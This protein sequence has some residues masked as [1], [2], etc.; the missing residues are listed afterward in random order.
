[1]EASALNQSVTAIEGPDEKGGSALDDLSPPGEGEQNWSWKLMVALAIVI[2]ALLTVGASIVLL[3]TDEVQEEPG[4]PSK[5]GG[6][7]DVTNSTESSV[8]TTIRSTTKTKPPK[9]KITR[10][11]P[12]STTVLPNQ[13]TR[14][15][16]DAPAMPGGRLLCTVNNKTEKL[17][18]LPDDGV[19]DFLFYDSLSKDDT[20]GLQQILTEKLQP[21]ID[22][23]KDAQVTEV[24]LSLSGEDETLHTS[25]TSQF[26]QDNFRAL[27]REKV[28]HF[29]MLNLH[30]SYAN[31]DNIKRCLASLMVIYKA[32]RKYF[33]NRRT[34]YTVLG[35]APEFPLHSHITDALRQTPPS[36]VIFLTHVSFE[37]RHHDNCRMLPASVLKF[38]DNLPRSSLGYGVSILQVT[39]YLSGIQDQ[40]MT[41]AISFTMRGHFYKPKA[42]PKPSASLFAPFSP[43]ED[44]FGIA[45][46]EPHLLC[47]D[48][49]SSFG[50][51]MDK[52]NVFAFNQ[53]TKKMMMFENDY[54]LTGK[55]CAAVTA[56][57]QVRFEIAA[58]DVIYDQGL[59]T[60]PKFQLT[61]SPFGRVQT[62]G[63]VRDMADKFYASRDME[64]CLKLFG[65]KAEWKAVSARSGT[66]GQTGDGGGTSNRHRP[67]RA[68]R[69]ANLQ[70]S[71]SRMLPD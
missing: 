67:K 50:Y 56:N 63:L 66:D 34:I 32:T 11:T 58:Y 49:N 68:L 24:G 29:G 30:G 16:D 47:L 57:P 35:M 61:S 22:Y 44:F 71:S 25:L 38:P 69:R 12:A 43:C 21:I 59:Y 33:R 8:Q 36:L 13:S 46:A 52:R 7:G 2:V 51:E 15:P 4:S 62:L 14:S 65:E 55:L 42:T 40:G 9:P 27:W 26:I 19:C 17:T 39:S 54:S 45:D 20:L 6:G 64:S 18:G 41:A 3:Q 10:R 60:C 1:M 48:Y 28:Y 37:D 31:S 5:A 70:P 53:T 23:A